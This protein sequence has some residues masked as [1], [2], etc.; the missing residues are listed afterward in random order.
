MN[1]VDLLTRDMVDLIG[2]HL[3]IFRKNQ[4]LIG[5]DVMRTLSSEERDERLKQHLILS[6]ELHPALLSSDHEYK[7]VMNFASPM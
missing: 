4:A 7:P 5:A 6:Q 3:D 1:L 2:N